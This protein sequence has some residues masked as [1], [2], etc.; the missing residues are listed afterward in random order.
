MKRTDIGLLHRYAVTGIIPLCA[1]A[2]LCK[3]ISYLFCNTV[4]KI[5]KREESRHFQEL[6]KGVTACYTRRFIVTNNPSTT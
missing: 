3:S 2:R 5:R 6:R 4:T 1:C